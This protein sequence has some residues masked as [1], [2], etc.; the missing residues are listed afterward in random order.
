MPNKP[1]LF[2][3][4][5]ELVA[6]KYKDGIKLNTPAQFNSAQDTTNS[7]GWPTIG[8]LLQLPI[9]VY[10]LSG[11]SVMQKINEI[12]A[13]TM[14][15]ASIKDSF[16]K[17]MFDISPADNAEQ[18]IST[19]RAVVQTSQR[20]IVEDQVIHFDH[21]VEQNFLTIKL[22]WYG[23]NHQVI[24]IFGCSILYGVQPF[25]E[26]LAQLVRYGFLANHMPNP[27]SSGFSHQ[28]TYFSKREKDCMYFLIRGKTAKETAQL[29]GLSPRTVENY[30]SNIKIKLNVYSKSELIDKI[31]EMNL[32]ESMSRNYV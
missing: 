4:S 15:F 18:V 25:A 32:P 13:A 14:G 29:L 31:F 26:T 27:F 24:G 21:A 8:N 23:N 10:F 19:D 2:D 5:N 7:S 9:N 6:V 12:C 20:K 28:E 17:S 16:G 11:T 3:T 22:P 1:S 30:L